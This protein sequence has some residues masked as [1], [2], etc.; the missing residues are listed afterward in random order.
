MFHIMLSE[1]CSRGSMVRALRFKSERLPV[2]IQTARFCPSGTSAPTLFKSSEAKPSLSIRPVGLP[3]RAE[4]CL[5]YTVL[6]WNAGG[7]LSASVLLPNTSL[8]TK[9]QLK[10]LCNFNVNGQWF[11]VQMQANQHLLLQL[12][13]L[14]KR[15]GSILI[16][17]NILDISPR[18]SCMI[19]ESGLHLHPAG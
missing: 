8:L 6:K 3:P 16:S 5:L 18:V 19:V 12:W 1:I 10:L 4:I 9:A 14:A 17:G 15:I 11:K 2:L 13:I 7:E